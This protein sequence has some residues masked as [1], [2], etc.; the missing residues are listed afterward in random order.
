VVLWRLRPGSGTLWWV[1]VAGFTM[2]MV[3]S[4]L[5]CHNGHVCMWCMADVHQLTMHVTRHLTGGQW[6]LGCAAAASSEQEGRPSAGLSPTGE[7]YTAALALLSRGAPSGLCRG[8]VLGRGQ[9][10]VCAQ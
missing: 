3:Q 1:H 4:H 5:A 10:E 9:S 2:G 8:G 6:S 7:V